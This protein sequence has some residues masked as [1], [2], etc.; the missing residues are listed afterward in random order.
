MTWFSPFRQSSCRPAA[1]R[2]AR[3]ERETFPRLKTKTNL[4]G[5]GGLRLQLSSF[6]KQVQGLHEETAADWCYALLDYQQAEEMLSPNEPALRLRLAV[7][8]STLGSFCFQDWSEPEH[9]YS[10]K[11]SLTGSVTVCLYLQDAADMF[12]MAIMYNPTASLYYEYRSK[13]L[14]RIQNLRGARE[15]LIRL[16]ILDPDNEEIPPMMMN[17]FPGST[18]SEVLSSTKG[19]SLRDELRETIRVWNSSDPEKRLEESLTVSGETP[20]GEAL[21][22]SEAAQELSLCVSRKDLQNAANTLLQ[23]KE[24]M[25]SYIPACP[26]LRQRSTSPSHLAEGVQ[27]SQFGPSPGCVWADGGRKG[28]AFHTER[29]NKRLALPSCQGPDTNTSLRARSRRFGPR[30]THSLTG[31]GGGRSRRGRR[32]FGL[33]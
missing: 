18:V 24:A 13:A 7:I 28:A 5:A 16:L 25:E 4:K 12:S 14:R 26:V 2:Q 17:L 11:N 33:R 21:S 30:S 29:G 9:R 15:D 22:L 31:P 19:Q 1:V 23:V 8:H 20:E 3:L 27:S 32:L 6:S 10:H